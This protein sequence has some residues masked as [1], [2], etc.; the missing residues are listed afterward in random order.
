M[1]TGVPKLKE[2]ARTKSIFT[3][4]HDNDVD[5]LATVTLEIE[6]ESQDP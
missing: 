4:H 1:L 2:F 3:K 5:D 6:V